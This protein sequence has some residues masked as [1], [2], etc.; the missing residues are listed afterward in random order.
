MPHVI[1]HRGSRAN[2]Q[3]GCAADFLSHIRPNSVEL[4]VSSPP[5]FMGKSYDTSKSVLDFIAEHEIVLPLLVRSLKEGG[6]LCWQIG[7]HVTDNVVI[8][9][10][11]IVYDICR[12]FP[13]LKLRNRIVW[14]FG[15]GIH[16]KK[17]FSG[18]HETILW[19]TKGSDYYF[20]LDEVRMRQKYPGKKSYKGPKKGEWSGNPL[21][22]N[23]SD[24]W[25]I[26]NVK[27]RHVE[28]TSHPCQFPIA[29]VQRLVRALTSKGDLV[30]DP[31][32]GS[33]TSAVASLME[34]RNFRGCE[35]DESY[36]MIALERIRALQ[37]GVLPV[38]LDV[39]VRTPRNGEA[40]ARVPPH[41]VRRA[42]LGGG[43]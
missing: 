13:I 12:R 18:R 33:G 15:H 16:A 25:D 9:L 30:I 7:H 42:G 1:S 22:K 6:S 14:T 34:G 20:S 41:F 17:R 36:V 21:G 19:F 32:M 8:P 11:Y 31:Y 10:D 37:K 3:V 23:P 26:P 29:L 40:V 5:Y 27:A 4:A 24:V 39:P 28:K 35:L 2:L 43:Q 38:R